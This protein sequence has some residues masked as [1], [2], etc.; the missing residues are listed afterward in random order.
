M[1]SAQGACVPCCA[2]L[3][4][5][6]PKVSMPSVTHTLTLMNMRSAGRL[7]GRGRHW[8]SGRLHAGGRRGGGFQ[9]GPGK[10]KSVTRAETLSR[11]CKNHVMGAKAC[12]MHVA[13][14]FL[15]DSP[16]YGG[17]RSLYRRMLWRR[18]GEHRRPPA[19]EPPA[20]RA[21]RQMK[22]V[23]TEL[24]VPTGTQH[25]QQRPAQVQTLL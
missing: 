23:S 4:C 25:Q 15:H 17:S 5:R 22:T 12:K 6:S 18:T 20:A 10:S 16:V 7:P 13:L 11:L 21:Q 24:R 1:P 9:T 2:V 3:L 14:T 19:A 8:C